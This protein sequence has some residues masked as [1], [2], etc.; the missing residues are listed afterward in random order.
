MID[1]H[2]REAIRRRGKRLWADG[3]LSGFDILD[4]LDALEEAED[5]KPCPECGGYDSH[6]TADYHSKL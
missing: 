2:R 6:C 3:H 1:A 5:L 4:L